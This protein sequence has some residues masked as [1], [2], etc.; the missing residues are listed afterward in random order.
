MNARL[1]PNNS[2]WMK[3]GDCG[4]VLEEQPGKVAEALRLFIQGLGYSLAAFERR[5]SSARKLSYSNGS[6]SLN[7]NSSRKS[8][9]DDGEDVTFQQ[10]HIQENP[11][12]QC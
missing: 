11:I 2:T 8:S 5:R 10:V 9:V 4:M 12:A 7:G 6:D 3:L 1:N